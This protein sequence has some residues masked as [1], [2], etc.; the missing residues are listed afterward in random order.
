MIEERNSRR[1]GNG[2]FFFRGKVSASFTWLTNESYVAAKLTPIS[3]PVKLRAPE[4]NGCTSPA[5]RKTLSW[6]SNRARMWPH[7][8]ADLARPPR[9]PRAQRAAGAD[10]APHVRCAQPNAALAH[11]G[12][13]PLT[14]DEPRGRP[15][16]PSLRCFFVD[17]RTWPEAPLKAPNLRRLRRLRAQLLESVLFRALRCPQHSLAPAKPL[18]HNTSLQQ[19]GLALQ[20]RLRCPQARDLGRTARLALLVALCR[21]AAV[22][23]QP[24][25]VLQEGVQLGLRVL[26]GCVRR[27]FAWQ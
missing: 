11:D 16:G 20:R 27:H 19:R 5:S 15:L 25:L 12:L 1:S 18:V 10:R 24:G 23:L 4:H 2:G 3:G 26:R 22:A 6:T 14:A 7:P 13:C 17:R 8:S 9:S 21:A